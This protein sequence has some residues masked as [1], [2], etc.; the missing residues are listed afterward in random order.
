MA[1]LVSEM[2]HPSKSFANDRQEAIWFIEHELEALTE[3]EGFVYGDIVILSHLPLPQILWFR[4][5]LSVG[6]K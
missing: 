3:K 1:I 5:C 2:G 4:R 6:K